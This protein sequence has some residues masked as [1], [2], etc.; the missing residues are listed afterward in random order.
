MRNK[1]KRASLRVDPSAS[2]RSPQDDTK[3][4][5]RSRI[6]AAWTVVGDFGRELRRLNTLG[7]ELPQFANGT[8]RT[9]ARIIRE[10]LTTGYRN[11][12]PCC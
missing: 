12:P 9:R 3:T 6:A 7:S 11:H 1:Q 8:R 5:T 4:A 2:L 10:R